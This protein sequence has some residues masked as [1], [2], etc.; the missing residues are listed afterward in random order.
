MMDE[1]QTKILE[2]RDGGLSGRAISRYLGIP[3]NT[4]TYR[5][6]SYLGDAKHPVVTP[7]QTQ[8]ILGSLLGDASLYLS[9]EN[10]HAVGFC[11]GEAQIDYLRL[12]H[13]LLGSKQKLRPHI[14]GF[15]GGKPRYQFE[16]YNKP[17]LRDVVYPLCSQSRKKTVTRPWL[18]R[19]TELGLAFWYQDDGHCIMGGSRRKDGSHKQAIVRIA[20]N[21][22]GY[23]EL[24]IIINYFLER[25]GIRF[26]RLP[27]NHGVGIV[28]RNT[29]AIR[30]LDLITPYTIMDY[31]V[32]PGTSG[33]G[34]F[35]E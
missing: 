32:F 18:D 21:S 34:D 9:N 22:F 8:L 1:L 15:P 33:L 23:D 26:H 2:L 17:Y 29:N 28:T 20:T 13:K 5:L 30:F 3:K 7:I 11:H 24:V 25:W 35:W 31:K 16:Y 19:L 6:R 12:K 4:I 27:P 10:V 14:G